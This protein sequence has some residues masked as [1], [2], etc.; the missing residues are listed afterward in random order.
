MNSSEFSRNRLL[1]ICVPTFNRTNELDRQL[2]WLAEEICGFE[3]ECEVIIS[4]NCSED[5]TQ[6]I[7]DK[8]RSHFATV[9]FQSNRNSENIGWMRNF[10][11]LLNASSSRYTWMI[12]DDDP[13]KPGTLAFVVNT[14]KSQP[15]LSLI[16][17]NFSDRWI[18]TGK[19]ATPN[20]LST[21]LEGRKTEGMT[22]FEECIEKSIGSVM[23]LTSTVFQTNLARTALRQ[24]SNSVNNW[25]GMAYW[26]G[27]CAT[28][29]SVLVTKENY[30]ECTLGA[31]NWS[32]DPFIWFRKQYG[33]I[34]EL[35][36]K[37]FELGYSREFCSKMILRSVRD[38][39]EVNQAFRIA[40]YIL[41]CFKT[42]PRSS[43][44]VLRVC[45]LA[46][47]QAL[48]GFNRFHKT[49]PS[50]VQYNRSS[51]LE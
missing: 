38:E 5:N 2:S 35:Y 37:L 20:W 14:L 34:P 15:D 6:E 49:Y 50:R 42:A 28:Q 43:A 10:T 46:I 23:F 44:S 7:V 48:F 21:H 24:W 4:D 11:Y 47:Y 30:V 33:D 25:A 18:E 12:G 8:W 26:T 39:F 32:K 19:V 41:W 51:V 16:F 17:L 36:L 40:K 27:Y 13:I 22:V 31:S 29:G 45:V 9:S 1:S 3:A